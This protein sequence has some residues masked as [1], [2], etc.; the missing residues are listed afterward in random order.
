[1]EIF[2]LPLFT[3]ICIIVCFC[4][5]ARTSAAESIKALIHWLIQSLIQSL[6]R[7]SEAVQ[8]LKKV[9]WMKVPK[10]GGA[11]WMEHTLERIE[12]IKLLNPR[13]RLVV[14][15][16][17]LRGS[18]ADRAP[19]SL[20]LTWA[21]CVR[22]SA[23]DSLSQISTQQQEFPISR[24]PD[25]KAFSSPLSLRKSGPFKNTKFRA[26][27]LESCAHTLDARWWIYEF[28]RMWLR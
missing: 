27:F 18:L 17:A 12:S 13:N 16:G 21:E 26:T 20:M 10:K 15:C 4:L 28:I 23:N 2:L 8:S 25:E 24:I 7:L 19:G 11:L 14:L 3:G 9:N 6:I 22:E 1:M 5:I